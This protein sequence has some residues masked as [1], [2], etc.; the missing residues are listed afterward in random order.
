MRRM[1]VRMRMMSSQDRGLYHWIRV[2]VLDCA[3][4]Y[5]MIARQRSLEPV[6]LRVELDTM[7]DMP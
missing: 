2:V 4:L 3:D 1:R 7:A 6:D 5:D